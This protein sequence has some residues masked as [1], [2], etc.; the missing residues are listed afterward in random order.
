MITGS[1]GEEINILNSK[2]SN[3]VS[4]P[5]ESKVRLSY[6]KGRKKGEILCEISPKD[7][8]YKRWEQQ[9]R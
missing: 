2:I 6:K 8:R 7:N 3:A 9:E 5:T 1:S 4:S